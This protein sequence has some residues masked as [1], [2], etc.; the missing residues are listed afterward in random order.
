MI[1]SRWCISLQIS[2]LLSMRS[3]TFRLLRNLWRCS[4]LLKHLA[5][6]RIRLPHPIKNKLSLSWWLL[7]SCCREIDRCMFA[8][9]HSALMSN[10]FKIKA[11]IKVPVQ[12]LMRVYSYHTLGMFLWAFNSS[13]TLSLNCTQT[14]K[15]TS[16]CWK[17]STQWELLAWRTA[18]IS[19]LT[20]SKKLRNSLKRLAKLILSCCTATLS[21]K[22]PH[23]NLHKISTSISW[24]SNLYAFLSLRTTIRRAK[25]KSWS[26]RFTLKTTTFALSRARWRISIEK[27]EPIC[28]SLLSNVMILLM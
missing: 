14:V 21:L 4:H 16:F 2:M 23:L 27:I 8:K 10:S 19:D 18:T 11:I 13:K 20:K 6:L 24:S 25:V 9:L 28:C 15:T 22:M 3:L 1:P 26:L 5:K 7:S 12:R 17:S